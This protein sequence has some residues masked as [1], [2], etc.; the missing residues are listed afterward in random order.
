LPKWKL[1]LMLKNVAIE[2]AAGTVPLL[3]DLFDVAFK[4]NLR[5]LAILEEHFGIRSER[6]ILDLRAN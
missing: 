1:A 3:G 5:N 2:A 6:P 4:A